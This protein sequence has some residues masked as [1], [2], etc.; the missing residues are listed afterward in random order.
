MEYV[1]GR[2]L[3]ELIVTRGPCPDPV[4]ISYVRQVLAAL[5]YAH[6]NGHRPPATSSRTTSSSTTRGRVK[7]ATSA[8]RGRLEPDDR[9]RARSSA[10]RSTSRPSRRA[11]RPS[12]SRPISTR[13]ASSSTSCSP[14]RCPFTGETPVEIAMKHL[15][16]IPEHPRLSGTEIPARPRPRRSPRAREGARGPYRPREEMDRD[17]E[18]V[19]RGEASSPRPRRRRTMVLPR[20]TTAGHRRRAPAGDRPAPAAT[21]AT[22]P[23]RARA[24]R[25][26]VVAVARRGRAGDRPRH[27]RPGSL[28]QRAA[29]RSTRTK[30]VAWTTTTGSSSRRP[31]R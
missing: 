17:L 10:P 8:S 23:T 27:R 22:A 2:T 3:K 25:Q 30:P 5:R 18:L 24:S 13:P 9:G 11:A 14:E 20:E 19:G 28:R 4:A 12:T 7:V 15:S 29:T 21:S 31:S 6:R 16:Q 1:E 26:A